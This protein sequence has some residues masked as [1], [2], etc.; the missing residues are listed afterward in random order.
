MATYNQFKDYVQEFQNGNETAINHLI[1][2]RTNSEDITELTINDK[3]LR[4]FFEEKVA[5][6]RSM[7]ERSDMESL[8]LQ[9]L[10]DDTGEEKGV[11][12]TLDPSFSNTQMLNYVELRWKGF[13]K[14]NV[15]E[16]SLFGGDVSSEADVREGEEEKGIES[17]YDYASVESWLTDEYS[18]SYSDFLE[19]TGGVESLMSDKQF[20]MFDMTRDYSKS[21]IAEKLGVSKANVTQTIDRAHKAIRKS[22]VRWRTV[23]L[24]STNR[25]DK[26]REINEFE[27]TIKRIESADPN[28]TFDYYTF[29]LEWLLEVSS[30]SYTIESMQKNKVNAEDDMD[31][32][33]MDNCD[34]KHHKTLITVLQ[35]PYG[36]HD[37]RTRDTFTKGV[38][39]ALRNYVAKE[40]RFACECLESVIDAKVDDY[41]RVIKTFK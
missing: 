25:N 23:Q 28:D 27:K 16:V 21:E 38:H 9:F 37:K 34:K 7:V 17:L 11:M 39:Q 33:V 32:V 31:I 24:I 15:G 19:E 8:L 36:K 22:Y 12:Y 41:G 29:T 18:D 40:K 4:G 2:I 5:A 35:D 20:E 13:V 30:M 26:T 3:I 6:Y 14:D 1:S 10:V